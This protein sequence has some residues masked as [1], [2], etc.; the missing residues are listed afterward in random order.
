MLSGEE[1]LLAWTKIAYY[2]YYYYYYYVFYL[3]E[4]NKTY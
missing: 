3:I 2:Y 4:I 1:R